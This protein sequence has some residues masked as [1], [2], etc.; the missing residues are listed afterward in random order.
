LHKPIPVIAFERGESFVFPSVSEASTAYGVNKKIIIDRILDGCT[1][2]DGYTTL[3]WY[4]PQEETIAEF[5]EMKTL[6]PLYE[7]L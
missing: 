7:L 2:K 6:I 3:D 4:S 1:L 5:K